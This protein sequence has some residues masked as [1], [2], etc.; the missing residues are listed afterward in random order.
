MPKDKEKPAKPQ[1][2]GG[3]NGDP[4]AP[5]TPPRKP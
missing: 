5:P 2:F 4:P 1:P 3:G